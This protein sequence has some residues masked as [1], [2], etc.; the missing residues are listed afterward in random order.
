M[1]KVTT[2]QTNK[3]VGPP[4][5]SAGS[6]SAVQKVGIPELLGIA[7]NNGA[8]TN[9]VTGTTMTLSSSPY[10]FITAFRRDDDTQSNYNKYWLAARIGVSAT[11][12]VAS[13]TDALAS[14]TRKQASQW[15]VKGTFRDTS[16]R[17]SEVNKL[18]STSLQEA[19]DAIVRD[20]SSEVFDALYRLTRTRKTSRSRSSRLWQLSSSA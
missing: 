2:A 5:S 19:A 9:N 20:A 1:A 10:G 6:T 13:S 17:S 18:F 4:P 7:V 11:F 16:V 12:N 3:Q 15:Q 14:V 8:V